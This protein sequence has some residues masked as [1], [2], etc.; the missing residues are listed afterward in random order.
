M[1]LRR[2]GQANGKAI[3]QVSMCY[4]VLGIAMHWVSNLA[5]TGFVSGA[6]GVNPKAAE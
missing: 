5:G 2:M 4:G 3:K 6:N 1:T